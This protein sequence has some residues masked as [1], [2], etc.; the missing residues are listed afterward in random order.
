MF[1]VMPC[2]RTRWPVR[3]RP[4]TAARRVRQ[5]Y[6]SI[7]CLTVA[8]VIKKTPPAHAYC[9]Q[10]LTREVD[11][12]HQDGI[13]GRP[14]L[15]IPISR[16][17]LDGGSPIGDAHVESAEAVGGLAY[18]CLDRVGSVMVTRAH[19]SRPAGESCARPVRA[20]LP[21]ARRW[22]LGTFTREALGDGA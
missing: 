20:R 11:G 14:P 3:A 15:S 18:E 9:G 5:Q 12:A 8:E 10:R 16:K 13:D 1:T 4:V 2:S 22:R 6:P 19:T 17:L 7:G 21:D